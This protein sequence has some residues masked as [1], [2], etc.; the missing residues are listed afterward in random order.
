MPSRFGQ[1]LCGV[2]CVIAL[3]GC[4]LKANWRDL[5]GQRRENAM[6]EADQFSCRQ[7]IGISDSSSANE[8]EAARPQIMSCMLGRGWEIA[9]GDVELEIEPDGSVD[10]DRVHLT[11]MTK[12]QFALMDLATEKPRPKLKLHVDHDGIVSFEKVGVVILVI[13]KSGLT[14]GRVGVV[15]KPPN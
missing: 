1:I 14:V 15:T 3:V 7:S 6:L 11:D 10:L 13:Q 2:G 9:S 5:T 8:F 12:L 4:E